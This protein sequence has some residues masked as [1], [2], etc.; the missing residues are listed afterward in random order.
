M[1]IRNAKYLSGGRINCEVEH[2]KYGWVPFTSMPT[3]E[4]QH[5]YDRIINGEAGV[6]APA[7]PDPTVEELA[8]AARETMSASN[9][10]ARLALSNAG[11]LPIVETAIVAA[12]SSTQLAWDRAGYFRRLSPLV[13]GMQAVLGWTDVEMDDLFIAAALIEA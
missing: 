11:V 8:A 3:G 10:Q 1:N 9:L 4:T 12:G 2:P 5:I 7:D 6:I 13:L